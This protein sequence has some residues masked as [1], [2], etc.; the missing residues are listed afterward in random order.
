MTASADRSRRGAGD[1]V[2]DALVEQRA[3]GQ[4]R[5]RVVERLVGE[6]LLERLALADVAA[7]EHDAA[8]RRVVEQV[9]VEDLEVAQA[10]RRWCDSRHSI[11]SGRPGRRRRRRSAA[12]QPALLARRAEGART[13]G[14]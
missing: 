9:G 7:V 14:R 4:V 3:V 5:D 13:A 12:Q 8:D 1:G 11:G 2:A 10:R 6:L